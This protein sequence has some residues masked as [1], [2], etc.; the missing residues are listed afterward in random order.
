MPQKIPAAF[1]VIFS[2]AFANDAI[3]GG[4]LGILIMGFQRAAF[5]NEAGLGSAAIAHSAAKSKYPVQEGIVALLEPFIDTVV[6]C[7]MTAL[8]I[9][10]TGAYDSSNPTFAGHEAA[11]LTSVALGSVVSWFPYVLTIAVV[12]F[13]FSTMI[14]W[15]YYGERATVYLFSERYSGA[16]KVILVIVV[17]LGFNRD[18]H[19]CL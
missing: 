11:A 8:V 13:A 3:A 12:L 19:Q 9:V 5:S 16:Y 2:T 15:S 6:V 14:S 1:G 10:I 18:L 17:F 7:S 4:F